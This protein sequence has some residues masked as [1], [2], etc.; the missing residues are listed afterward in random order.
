[1]RQFFD[2]APPPTAAARGYRRLLA[3]YYNLL[4]PEDSRVLEIGCGRGELLADLRARQV[5]GVDISSVQV[6]AARQKVPHGHFLV[7]AGEELDLPGPFDVIII[8]DT[9]N[10]AADVQGM[11][12]RL[13]TVS[14][15]ETRLI[16]N[17]QSNLWR[18]FLALGR[19]LGLGR[20][21]P[22]SSWLS[23]QDVR[24]MLALAD[25]AL[26]RTDQ[27]L[28]CPFPPR[29]RLEDDRQSLGRPPFFPLGS[30]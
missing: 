1:M 29:R 20:E 18:P 15:P 5:T 7:Q 21:G 19:I 28:L 27:R 12:E 2:A 13:R 6:E 4:I 3:H 26:V 9:L 14:T 24:N 16:L 8:S 11:L 17:F 23:Q 25:W 30:A 10:F 22:Q